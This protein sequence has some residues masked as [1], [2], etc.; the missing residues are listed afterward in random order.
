I[1]AF[2]SGK[3]AMMIEGNWSL[4]A[5]AQ[6]FPELNFETLEL[7]TIGGNKHTMAF[8]VGYA[9]NNNTKNLDNATTF[10]NYMTNEGQA[11]WTQGAGVLPSRQSVTEATDVA[12]DSLK[13]PHIAGA[14][15]ATVWSRGTKLPIINTA[16]GNQFSAVLNGM[17]TVEEA[18]KALDKEANDEIA[19]QQ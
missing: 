14:E 3:A 10:V 9:I 6:D 19:R 2:G 12:S 15:Y 5:F 1:A 11:E 7:P 4:G 8:T 16:Y 18:L 17:S 13:A